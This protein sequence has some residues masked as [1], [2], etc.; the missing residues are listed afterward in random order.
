MIYQENAPRVFLIYSIFLVLNGCGWA[1]IDVSPNM[2]IVGYDDSERKAIDEKERSFKSKGFKNEAENLR[3]E[4]EAKNAS[5]NTISIH[6]QAPLYFKKIFYGNE[7]IGFAEFPVTPVSVASAINKAK[8][9]LDKCFALRQEIAGKK[10]EGT[11]IIQVTL[12]GS[13]F[14]V[15]KDIYPSSISLRLKAVRIE[16]E[17]GKVIAP[18]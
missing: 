11:P 14:F 12:V 3:T 15:V 1:D 4:A 7:I 10:P 5:Y 16:I 13:E 9:H 18:K 17:S 8:P 2:R 6:S